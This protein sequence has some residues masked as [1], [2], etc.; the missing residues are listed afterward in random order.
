MGRAERRAL[1]P[2]GHK[3]RLPA[4]LL[5]AAAAAALAAAAAGAATLAAA[6]AAAAAFAAAAAASTFRTSHADLLF[7]VGVAR[8]PTRGRL[9]WPRSR[10][11]HP[12]CDSSPTGHAFTIPQTPE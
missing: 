6:A 7:K 4:A 8:T 2:G 10:D 1:G 5:A 12:G 3:V 9:A 11:L